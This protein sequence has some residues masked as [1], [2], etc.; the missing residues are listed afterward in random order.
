MRRGLNI[1]LVSLALLPILSGLA[2]ARLGEGILH[3]Q[4]RN[5]SDALV[6]QADEVFKRVG[7]TREDFHAT[8]PDGT[9]LRGWKVRPRSSNG[10]W[11]L[12]FHGVADNRAGML[13][14]AEFLH[15]HGYSILMM[16]ARAHGASGGDIATY[17]WKERDDTRAIVNSLYTTEPQIHCLFALGESMGGAIALQSAA[18]EPRIDGVVA[19]SAFANLREV[20]Y[21]YSGLH[22]SPWLGKTLFRPASHFALL[23]AE[24]AGGFPVEE[25]SP[26]KSVAERDFP[27]SLICDTLDLTIPCRHSE[28][29]FAAA[30]GRKE[31]WVVQGAGHTGAYSAS[32]QGFERRVLGFFEGVHTAKKAGRPDH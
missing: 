24:K 28:R 13:T 1:G 20:S 4:R 21:D 17:G 26:E 22:F 12:L 18:V 8:A 14:Y 3:P 27:V 19:E 32:P 15:R 2:G 23:E 31:L 6:S 16:D 25:V 10:D 29:I 30:R 5:L 9:I 7:A 11:V